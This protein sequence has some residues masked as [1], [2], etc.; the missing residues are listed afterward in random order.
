MAG[1][2]PPQDGPCTPVYVGVMVSKDDGYLWRR[3]DVELNGLMV[4]SGQEHMD[5]RSGVGDSP[6]KM[7]FQSIGGYWLR[8]KDPAYAQ[9]NDKLLI[10][11]SVI[12]PRVN[13]CGKMWEPLTSWSFV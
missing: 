3:Q 1:C 2:A 12:C 8:E 11:E 5:G 6:E 9:L 13:E 4:V 10:D 7:T